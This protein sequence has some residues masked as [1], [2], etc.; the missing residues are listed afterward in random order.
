[1]EKLTKELKVETLNIDPAKGVPLDSATVSY[2]RS[3]RLSAHCTAEKLG[4]LDPKTPL[5]PEEIRALEEVKVYAD[6]RYACDVM[7]LRRGHAYPPDWWNK[8]MASGM[9][10]KILER[11]DQGT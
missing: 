5:L 8:V 10:D 6:L 7:K 9:Y 3:I 2:Y 11:I 4:K 1:M